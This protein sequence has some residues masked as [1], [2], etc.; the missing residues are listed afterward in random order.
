MARRP[1]MGPDT[2][3]TGCVEWRQWIT[4][5]GRARQHQVLRLPSS[6]RYW[7]VNQNQ[8]FRQEQDGGYLWSPKAQRE[9]GQEPVLRDHAR[10]VAWR[11]GLLLR[12]HIHRRHRRSEEHT[13]ELQSLTHL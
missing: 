7:W 3:M 1:G 4:T 6:M 8:T 10:G 11:R 13:S 12:G 9:R 5:L 2:A